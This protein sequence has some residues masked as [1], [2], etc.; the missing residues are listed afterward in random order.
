[1]SRIVQDTPLVVIPSISKYEPAPIPVAA[2]VESPLAD[3]LGFHLKGK[4]DQSTHAATAAQKS[5]GPRMDTSAQVQSYLAAHPQQP[6][7]S[8][9]DYQ[10]RVVNG[11]SAESKHEVIF[12]ARE[13]YAPVPFIA[14]GAKRYRKEH[15]LPE[16]AVAINEQRA[17]RIKGEIV[18]R[19]FEQTPDQSSDPKVKAAFEDF[20]RQNHEQFD[21][22]TRPESQGGM[23]VKV[24]FVKT[25][26]PYKSATAQAEDLRQNH[27]ISIESGLGGKHESTMTTQEYD[28]FRAVH[29]VFGHAGVGGGFDRHGE[30]QAYLE[31]SSMYTGAGRKAMASEYHGVNTAVWAGAP[32][33]P[34]TGKSI[35]LP[36]KDIPQPWGKDGALVKAQGTNPTVYDVFF[37]VR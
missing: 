31:H 15:G 32:G 34:G 18:A 9:F 35:L 24:D 19:H 30:Y 20:K 12:Q 28:E 4:H 36:D 14:D 8:V 16:P 10:G 17:P 27:H 6:G 33:S 3:L 26:D 37:A 25:K 7:E 2:Q 29:D 5:T 13:R 21:F 22:M 1:M 11:L 23:G